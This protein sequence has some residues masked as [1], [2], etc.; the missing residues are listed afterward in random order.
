MG[1]EGTN[2]RKEFDMGK[3][4]GK[5]ESKKYQKKNGRIKEDDGKSDK[6]KETKIKRGQRENGKEGGK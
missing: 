2:H 3:K 4:E 6:I 1:N 5:E